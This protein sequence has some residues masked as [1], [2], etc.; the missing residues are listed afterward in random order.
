MVLQ[1]PLHLSETAFFDFFNPPTQARNEPFNDF[2]SHYI[3]DLLT[4]PLEGATFR[5]DKSLNLPV[6]LDH[7]RI[8]WEKAETRIRQFRTGQYLV[9]LTL[10][11]DMSRTAVIRFLTPTTNLKGDLFTRLMKELFQ[12]LGYDDIRL[13]VQKSGREIDIEGRHRYLPRLLRA[14]CKAHED[15]MGGTNLNTFLGAVMRERRKTKTAIDAF[16]ISLGGFT[17]PGKIQEEEFGDDQ[18]ILLYGP[19]VIAELEHY[20]LLVTDAVAAEQAGQCASRV[21]LAPGMLESI[22]LVAYEKGYAKVVYYTQYR[23]R[24]HFA[25][26]HADGTPLATALA[27]EVIEADRVIGGT[28]HQLGYLAP[29]PPVADLRTA[30]AK[31]FVQYRQWLD[32]ACGY[33]QLDGLPTNSDDTIRTP[34]LEN[35][36]IPLKAIATK[37]QEQSLEQLN[38]TLEYSQ[39]TEEDSEAAVIFSDHIRPV[40]EIETGPVPISKLLLPSVRLALLAP[41]GGGKSTLLKRIATEYGF[42]ERTTKFADRMPTHDWLPLVVRC[43]D[44]RDQARQPF[45]KILEQLPAQMSMLPEPAVAFRAHIHE[46]L[47]L[48]R[49]LVL[50]DGLDEIAEEPDRKVFAKNLLS[51]LIMFPQVTLVLTSREA[52]FRLVAD[53]IAS[54][55][56]T[57]KLAPFEE[58]DVQRLCV[59]WHAEV[60]N[61]SE[62]V[63]QK[64]LKLAKDIWDNEHIRRL[65]QNP[66]LLTTLLVVNRRQGGE[67]PK[68]RVKLYNKAV[69]VLIQ[70]WNAEA[71]EPLDEEETLTRLSYLACYMMEKGMQQIGQRELIQTLKHA[72][73]VIPEL[74]FTRTS[75]AVF[76]K[77]VEYRSSLLMQVGRKLVEEEEEEVFEFRHLTFQEYLAAKGYAD[78]F[79]PR[80]AEGLSLSKLLTPHFGQSSWRE[81]IPLAAVLSGRNAER[82]MVQLVNRC[83]N[84]SINK[85][86]RN[87][88]YTMPID[89]LRRC[90]LDEVKITSHE[91]LANA[92]RQL[93]RLAPMT[94]MTDFTS[95][96]LTTKAGDLYQ[97][98]IEQAYMTDAADWNEYGTSFRELTNYR[99]KQEF[100]GDTKLIAEQAVTWLKE[101]DELSQLRS[102]AAILYISFQESG[103]PTQASDTPFW[104]DIITTQ[105][106]LFKL[107]E[108][109]GRE[110]YEL[111]DYNLTTGNERLLLESCRAFCFAYHLMPVGCLPKASSIA[112]LFRILGQ[113]QE[114]EVKNSYSQQLRQVAALALKDQPLLS[115][116][117]LV[118]QDIGSYFASVTQIEDDLFFISHHSLE[119]LIVA[120]W[121]RVLPLTDEEL[122]TRID[123]FYEIS[124]L[125]RYG[126]DKE[127]SRVLQLLET[128]GQPGLETLSERLVKRK[129]RK[130]LFHQALDDDSD[131]PF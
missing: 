113:E 55:C 80:N 122:A 46:S 3:E 15:K 53:V 84:T 8:T 68:N 30:Q 36:F 65:A 17:E 105:I 117:A 21:G 120:G 57:Y 111:L 82:L 88:L 118:G 83:T 107:T 128:I 26:I 59:Q 92:L 6:Q 29:A 127:S 58:A 109:Q 28:L 39:L 78:G 27:R 90:I 103:K 77:Q 76:I 104:E 74:R 87:I 1:Q 4:E 47:Q 63:R 121:Y 12:A 16:F 125:F 93:G 112:T 61:S 45:I 79:H 43:R 99:L 101:T 41:P 98:L 25:L 114:S 2:L 60:I 124:P 31:A 32:E 115:R 71:F 52:G 119:L 66:L 130:P 20:R 97:R 34:K 81:V 64:A 13:D 40:V 56:Q 33:I 23:Q 110:L 37:E 24:T 116:N 131:L 86:Q 44:L 106:T 18:I 54:V 50:L 67:L 9:L 72:Q 95:D 10:T 7:L 96:I 85:A 69:E 89:I 91:L 35:L 5:L 94:L 75:P 49:V 102:L 126:D 73:Q 129:A 123:D 51:F 108:G 62:E 14:E 70:T 11:S 19:Q 38:Y 22:E 42:A 100:K 48:G